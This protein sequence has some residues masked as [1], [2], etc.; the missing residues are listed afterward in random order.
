MADLFLQILNMSISA[1]WLILAVLVTRLLLKK[2]PKWITVALWGMVAIR[3]VCPVSIESAL[4]LIPSAQT[5]S[6]DIMMQQNPGVHTGI[7]ALNS[8]INPVI[9][10]AFAPTPGDSANP[11]QILIPIAAAVW[12]LGIGIMALYAAIS[13]LQLKRKVHDATLLQENIYLS[14]NIPAPF[15][16]GIL[17]PKIYL[18]DAQ[19]THILAHERAHIRRGDHI[20]KTLGFALLALHWFNPLMWLGYILLCK[21]IELACDEKVIKALDHDAR[22]DYSQALLTCSVSRHTI[23]ACPLAFGEVSVKDRIKSVLHYK[24]PTLWII[25]AALMIS[26]ILGVCFLTNP[27]STAEELTEEQQEI[28]KKYPEYFGLDASNGLDVYVYQIA[29]HSYSFILKTHSNDHVM[30]LQV[31]FSGVGAEEMRIILSTYDI[32]YMQVHIIPFQHPLSSY[33]GDY[34]FTTGNEA[35]DEYRR[36]SYIDNIRN[37]IL[38]DKIVAAMPVYD[39]V[40]YDID[41]D[42]EEETCRL[43]MGPTSGI[44]SFYFI[45]L[46]PNTN[47]VEYYTLFSGPHGDISFTQND[48][49]QLQVQTVTYG[50]NATTYTLTVQFANGQLYYSGSDH[51]FYQIPLTDPAT[52]PN[53]K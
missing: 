9:D 30:P 1:N 44:S 31:S 2:A 38:R 15:V 40:L 35:Q 17:Q 37:M 41:S 14:E 27:P 18:T 36:N 19:Q 42:G 22:A 45:I 16:L 4:S 47:I 33:M 32:S 10:S 8:V 46:K 29:E 43:S 39:E 48:L 53:A 25:V 23:A 21:D 52:N 49:G 50:E 3:L 20:W 13:Y 6:P 28:M 5:V 7:D 11:L 51:P 34:F 26:A 24:K 12:L